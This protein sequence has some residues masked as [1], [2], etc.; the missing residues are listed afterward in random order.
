M[1]LKE[2]KYHKEYITN[3]I[4]KLIHTSRDVKWLGRMHFEDDDSGEVEMDFEVKDDD[5]ESGEDD[6]DEDE[7][8]EQTFTRSGRRV[9]RPNRF[10]QDL[11]G[12]GTDAACVGAT[13]VQYT[14][15]A[16][17]RPIRYHEAMRSDPKEVVK[18]NEAV[19]KEHANFVSHNA[20]TAIHRRDVPSDATVVGTTWVM[21][22]KADG[23]YK[24]RCNAHG[25]TQIHGQNYFKCTSTECSL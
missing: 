25:F 16:E 15:T 17:L 5:K 1:Q 18:W 19:M 13:G 3:P 21:K 4:T 24:A 7:V 10:E 11:I 23:T 22:K 14:N 12:I 20:V 9:R 2:R 6:F 8:E